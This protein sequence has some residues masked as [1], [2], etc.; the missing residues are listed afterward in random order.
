[1][2]TYTFQQLISW[3]Q[4]QPPSPLYV[5]TRETFLLVMGVTDGVLIETEELSE[6]PQREMALHVLLLIHHAAAQGFLVGLSLQ[7][8]LFNCPRLP[9]HRHT[10]ISDILQNALQ[11]EAAR[12]FGSNVSACLSLHV[13]VML[14]ACF[15]SNGQRAACR[16]STSS[17]VHLSTH[18][19]WPVHH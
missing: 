16:C 12:S 7:N 1:M 2:E 11:G 10:S 15:L 18:G 5:W 8:L 6:F 13:L 19:P 4:Q 9:A 3:V 17:S 14:R